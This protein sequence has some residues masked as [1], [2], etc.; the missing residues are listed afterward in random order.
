[1]LVAEGL[2]VSNSD[3][4]PASAEQAVMSMRGSVMPEM[5]EEYYRN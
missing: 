4:T 5:R 1:M 3:M 2:E